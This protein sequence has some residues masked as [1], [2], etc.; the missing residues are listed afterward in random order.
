MNI[1]YTVIEAPPGPLFVAE[2]RQGLIH[3][4]FGPE[5]LDHLTAFTRRWFPESRLLP[6]VVDAASQIQEYLEGKRKIFDLALD[7]RGTDFQ[8]ETWQALREIPY[9][10]TMT[11]GEVARSIGRLKAARAVGRACG[12]NPIG[13]VI[14]CHRV[15]G[16]GGQLTGFGGGLDWKRWLLDL[17]GERV[18]LR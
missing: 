7:V 2:T 18:T 1:A 9:G 12:A 8:K 10:R 3:V 15:L 5:G 4:S 13:V 17:E 6:S 16:S 14:P 11:Y